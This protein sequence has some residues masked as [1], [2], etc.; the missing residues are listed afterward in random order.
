[1]K[2]NL[3]KNISFV[4][5][6]VVQSYLLN[7]ILVWFFSSFLI[8]CTRFLSIKSLFLI[9]LLIMSADNSNFEAFANQNNIQMLDE[10][11]KYNEVEDG[12]I[13]AT[14]PWHQDP[15]YFNVSFHISILWNLTYLYCRKSKSLLQL[16]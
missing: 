5:R 1:M 6:N 4:W 9:E 15:N 7:L 12:Q 13:R 3:N 2:R 10:P 8:L 16:W 11:F 14:K